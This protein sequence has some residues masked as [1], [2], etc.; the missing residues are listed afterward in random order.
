MDAIEYWLFAHE[1]S[2][3]NT[4]FAALQIWTED[5]DH[6]MLSTTI[7]RVYTAFFYTQ[8]AQHLWQVGEEY[9]LVASWP[10]WTMSSNE[11]SYYKILDMKVAV[12]VWIFPLHNVE[13][14]T[15]IMFTCKKIYPLDLPPQEFAHLPAIPMPCITN[16]LMKKMIQWKTTHL[17][18]THCL[19]TYP[20]SQKRKM[21]RWKNIS[22]H[23]FMMT[24]F[25]GK[26]VPERHLYIHENAQHDLC[27]YPCS[28]DLNLLHFT[29]EDG[30]SI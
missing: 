18:M 1:F 5:L 7:E 6:Q 29:Q 16:W 10:H 21:M 19:A 13:N 22:W 15:H 14:H 20:A 27:L 17:K 11:H 23:Y 28:Y 12:K 4:S 9:Y 8:S 2:I 30:W 25:V 26:P 24:I 3:C